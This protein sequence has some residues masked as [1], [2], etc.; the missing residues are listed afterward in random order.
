MKFLICALGL[1][2]TVL[3]GN[4]APAAKN[5]VVI[6]EVTAPQDVFL[7]GE[8]LVVEVR[9]T[10]RSGIPL[11]FRDDVDWLSLRV[12]SLEKKSVVPLKPLASPGSMT[13][14]NGVTVTRKFDI[15]PCFDLARLGFYSVTA[16]LRV[17]ELQKEMTW[18]DAFRFEIVRG[19]K[20]WEQEVGMPVRGETVSAPV[21]RRYTL[22]QLRTPKE[23]RLYYRVTDPADAEI[24][25]VQSIGQYFP[26][27]AP[28]AQVDRLN[29]LH[30]LYQS[31]RRAFTHCVV[32]PDGELV[33]RQTYDG[34][35]GRPA[36]RPDAENRILVAGG[37]QVIATNDIPRIDPL[38][39]P[40]DPLPSPPAAEEPPKKESS[41][42]SKKK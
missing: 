27:T 16:T 2:L 38:L 5:Q 17:A 39:L 35:R 28:E 10:N 42:K 8:P 6:V 11:E 41:A 30:V 15:A 31:H 18:N 13:I 34:E 32:T 22:M 1:A 12:S 33:L 40:R 26:F 4:A 19:F 20:L 14:G 23:I 25:K 21:L 24:I 36:L 9:I 29:N 3:P 7:S 37:R